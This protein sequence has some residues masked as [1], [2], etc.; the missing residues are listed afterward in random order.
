MAS[1]HA[2]AQWPRHPAIFP[3]WQAKQQSEAAELTARRSLEAV[4]AARVA[5]EQQAQAAAAAEG[6]QVC[7][8][9][10]VAAAQRTAAQA[11]DQA[12]AAQQMAQRG[13]SRPK[14]CFF[15][16]RPCN[17]MWYPSAC[18]AMG[19][20]DV[21]AGTQY[22]RGGCKTVIFFAS[23]FARRRLLMPQVNS[24]SRNRCDKND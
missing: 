17:T 3:V 19:L 15:L 21:R 11:E 18:A 8:S 5:M 10:L 7:A 24:G 9:T 22:Y 20:A 13:P 2:R 6:T 4:Q 16:R 23:R 14:P 1:A 12:K